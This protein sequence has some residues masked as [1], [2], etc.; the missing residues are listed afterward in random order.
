MPVAFIRHL[1]TLAIHL[2]EQ[3]NI[4]GLLRFDVNTNIN[5]TDTRFLFGFE[6]ER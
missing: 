1:P 5:T 4:V 3:I 2:T 6:I